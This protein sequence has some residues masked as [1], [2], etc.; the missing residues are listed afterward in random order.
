MNKCFCSDEIF[1]LKGAHKVILPL[2][3]A[4]LQLHDSLVTLVE[5]IKILNK[6]S[7]EVGKPC[8]SGIEQ[9]APRIMM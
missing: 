1:R 2:Q 9:K 4:S 6:S 3:G 5:E 8:N 7:A